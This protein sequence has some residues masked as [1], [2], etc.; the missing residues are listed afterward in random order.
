MKRVLKTRS[1]LAP[2]ITFPNIRQDKL[3][4]VQVPKMYKNEKHLK[5]YN[6]LRFYKNNF[7]LVKAT[8][9]NKILFLLTFFKGNYNPISLAI[10]Q[11]NS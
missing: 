11:N 9:H 4:K 10:M 7:A 3:L 1:F 5:H 8:N 6:V 2:I